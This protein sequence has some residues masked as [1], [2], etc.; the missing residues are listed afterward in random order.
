VTQRIHI[1][2]SSPRTGTTLLTE[3]MRHGFAI[4]GFTEH[5]EHLR[6]PPAHPY[7]VYLTKSPGD[8]K[9]ARSYLR[10][11]PNLWILHL[12]RDPRDVIVSRHGRAPEVYWTNLALWKRYRRAARRLAAH[13]RF[14]TLRYEDL[15][16][17]PDAVQQQI[18]AFLPFLETTR[19]FSQVHQVASPSPDANDALGGLRPVSEA[20]IGV[21]RDHKPRIAAQI[22]RHGSIDRDLIE[23]GYEADRGWRRALVGVTPENGTSH[24]PESQSL[25]RRVRTWRKARRRLRRYVS[26]ARDNARGDGPASAPP[27]PFEIHLETTRAGQLEV[28]TLGA[29]PTVVTLAGLGLPATERFGALAQALAGAGFRTLAVN[30]RGVGASR[31]TLIDLT[32]PD[33][34]DDVFELIERGDGPVHVVGT[35]FG[36][37]VARAL[38]ARHP[39]WVR[40]VVL[41]AAGGKFKAERGVGRRHRTPRW[42][43]AARAHDRAGKQAP[44]ESWWSGGRAPT[45]VIQGLDDR[46]APP[47]NGRA[48]AA[49]HP[50]RV[51]LLELERV[52]HSPLRERP[53]QVIPAIV[54]FLAAQKGARVG[55]EGGRPKASPTPPRAPGPDGGR[56]PDPFG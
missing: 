56:Q 42:A 43:Q 22:A 55:T 41:I 16:A 40:S 25:R 7:R 2:G 20:S 6:R 49:E 5:E 50:E 1:V 38:A 31:G 26:Y 54:E 29:G 53:D 51:Q 30:L 46:I 11:D 17:E 39:E 33:L 35:A 4:D 9:V 10:I 36:N 3:L 47:A 28:G 21:W 12:V 14:L 23:L 37:R 32:L 27:G 19:A 8:V 45:L 13:P 18:A 52:G 24:F 48:L 15:V 44:L 34:V